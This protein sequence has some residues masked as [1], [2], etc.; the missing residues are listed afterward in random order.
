MR[1]LTVERRTNV[2]LQKEK[3]IQTVNITSLDKPEILKEVLDKW[4]N[5]IDLVAKI[6]NVPSGLIMQITEDSMKVFLKSRNKENPYEEGHCD[7]LGQGLF[8]ETVIGRDAELLIDN[9]LKYDE[10]RDNPDVNLNMI[11][12]YGL[13]IK[14][15]DNDFF[16]TICVLDKE[17]NAYCSNFRKLISEFKI[18]IE[19]DLDL[20]CQKQELRYYAEMDSLTSVY[21][22]RK[23]ESII[24]NQFSRSKRNNNP[25]T[26]AL[27]DLNNFKQINDTRGH[28]VGDDILKA[29]AKGVNT[30]IRSIDSFGRWGGDEFI[31]ICPDTDKTG[32]DI[33]LN[34][35]KT[36][37]KADMDKITSNSGFCIG[38]SE[39]SKKDANYSNAIKR[40]DDNLYISKE[41][42]SEL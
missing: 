34:K 13:P 32:I 24:S 40:A 36:I 37:V 31:L 27:F 10:W 38:V 30:R 20:L 15:P 35:L 14:W 4:Q 11:S 33:L 42:D 8:C 16:G 19:K 2:F 29:F 9:S 25:F 39:F 21:N 41:C 18:S 28:N 5:I 6:L 23:I 22:R 26:V 3:I 1:K 17:G 12:Y 7:K